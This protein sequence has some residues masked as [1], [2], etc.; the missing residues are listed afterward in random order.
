MAAHLIRFSSFWIY[1]LASAVLVFL[2]RRSESEASAVTFLMLIATGVFFWTFIEY[3]LHRYVFH[4]TSSNPALIRFFSKFHRAHHAHPRE[5]EWIL[6]RPR[7]SLP[8]SGIL[9]LLGYGAT[10][11]VGQTAGLLIGVWIG[12][13]YY[14][15][16]HYKVHTSSA[17]LGLNAQRSRH[18]R[19]HFVNESQGFGVTSPFWDVVFRTAVKVD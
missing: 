19:H 16:V 4:T 18:F 1:P 10:G 15:W 5:P 11:D 17:T 3:L 13:L 14:E 2:A 12:F 9:L 6:A 7:T 8:L